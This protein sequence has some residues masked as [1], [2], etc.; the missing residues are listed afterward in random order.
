MSDQFDYIVV[1]AGSAGCVVANRLSA[2]PSVR[3]LLLEAGPEPRS[4]WI[5]IPGAVAKLFLPGPHNWGN[6]TEP[7]PHLRDRRIYWA[8]GRGLGG[9][10][11]INGMIYMRGHPLDYEHWRQLG[12]PGWGWDDVL[13]L[14]E[15]PLR[16]NGG[17]LG[18]SDPATRYEFS[19]LFIEA[20]RQQG[21]A[22]RRD[23]NS[24]EQEGV[25]YLQFTIDKGLRCSSY[26][27]FLAPVRHRPNLTVVADALVERI[28]IADRLARGI[29]YR[30]KGERRSA[31][32]GREVILSGGAISS[33]HLLM[34]SGVGPGAHLREFGIDVVHD[35]PGVGRNLHDHGYASLIY[36]APARYSM[37]HRAQGANLLLEAARYAVTRRGI[38]A[39]GP[40]QVGLYA[41]VLDGVEQ[42]DIQLTIRPFSFDVGPKGI[43]MSKTPTVTVSACLLR[44]E[45]RGALTLRTADPADAPA[46]RA[47]YFENAKDRAT[48]LGGVR[49][50]ERIMAAPPLKGF[51]PIAPM[52]KDDETAIDQLRDFVGAVMHP[53]GSCRMGADDGAVVDP[54]LRVRGIAGLRVADASIMPAIVSANTNAPSIMIGEKAAEMILQDQRTV[55]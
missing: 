39:M 8:R 33:P 6:S 41:R 25:G 10:S 20:A 36:G 23:F 17:E 4:P 9:G 22:D 44:P 21:F 51:T 43:V 14:F 7:E 38:L 55:A 32:A 3:V 48:M 2:D 40:S 30:R 50:A 1:G 26:E 52:A 28:D 27:A 49:L 15:R 19:E 29:T 37:N 42:P 13:P 34:L 47:N 5:K 31:K 16:R 54:R 12:N 11:S 45:S 35:L 18:V 24:G 46:M 53:V